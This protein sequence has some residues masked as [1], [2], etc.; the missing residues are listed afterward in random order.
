MTNKTYIVKYDYF[1]LITYLIL[2][3]VGLYMQLNISAV[4]PSMSYFFKQFLWFIISV[5]IMWIS[6][7]F[8]DLS[9][10]RKYTFLLVIFTLGLLVAVLI[11]GHG[12][13]GTQRWLSVAGFNIQPS[14]IA[15]LILIFYFAHILDKQK[16]HIP[17]TY[18]AGFLKYFFPLILISLTFFILIFMEKHFSILII[19]GLTLFSMLFLANIRF[20]TLFIIVVILLGSFFLVISRGE[21][22]RSRRMD[23]YAK[24]SLFHKLLDK[25][26]KDNVDGDFQIKQSLISLACGKLSGTGPDRGTGKLYFLPEAKTDYI[27][28][29][30]G[31]EFG[32][33]GAFI[34]LLL[35]VILFFRSFFSSAKNKDM[36]LRFAG[37]GLALNI[38]LNAMV[39][40]GV[41]I[42][43][44]P[45]TGITL[46]FISYGG[47]SLLVNSLSIGLLLN[48]SSQRVAL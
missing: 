12:P 7:K 32:F 14:L 30:I 17:Q 44:L 45:S 10:L 46:P 48:I 19:L 11:F 42:S 16:K 8:I 26:V 34:I 43:A 38:F 23:I 33:I 3:I 47:T 31:E 1:I 18:P 41:S 29:I 21:G 2:V 5:T 40:I 28:A 37:Y 13:N 20:L 4:R 36:F 39:N 6:F 35:Y 27:F 24:Y 9:K 15:R 22:Y 25:E